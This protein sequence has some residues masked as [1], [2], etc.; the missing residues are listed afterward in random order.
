M[1]SCITATC[2]TPLC[3]T[4]LLMASFPRITMYREV[5][6]LPGLNIGNSS[7]FRLFRL[8]R[9][10]LSNTNSRSPCQDLPH[11]LF[12]T[13][14]PFILLIS[15]HQRIQDRPRRWYILHSLSHSRGVLRHGLGNT[16]QFLHGVAFGTLGRSWGRRKRRRL[17]R[18]R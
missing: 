4:Y 5:H 13:F 14:V 6:V 2:R 3:I 7:L 9:P 18:M 12:F 1:I 8:F 16:L 15:P 11:P 10:H 17:K